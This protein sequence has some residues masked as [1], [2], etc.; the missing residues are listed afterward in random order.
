M[1]ELFPGMVKEEKR[2]KERIPR[3]HYTG[4]GAWMG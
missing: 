2:K 3:Q 4:S 1:S